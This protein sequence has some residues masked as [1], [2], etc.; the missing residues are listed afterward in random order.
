MQHLYRA[1]VFPRLDATGIDLMQKM[2]IYD[3]AKRITV[4]RLRSGDSMENGQCSLGLLLGGGTGARPVPLQGAEL[5]PSVCASL[6]SHL[7]VICSAGQGGDE[8]PLF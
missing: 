5:C 7:L 2:F 1:Q 4:S 8:P 6:S 3:P